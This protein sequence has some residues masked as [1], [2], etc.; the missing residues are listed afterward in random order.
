[1]GG[2]GW[3]TGA[4][5]LPTSG[6]KQEREGANLWYPQPSPSGVLGAV[7]AEGAAEVLEWGRG[8]LLCW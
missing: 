3:G 8:V 4:L 2:A 1:M 7:E 5:V 6:R